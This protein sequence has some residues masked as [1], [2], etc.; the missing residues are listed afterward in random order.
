MSKQITRRVFL[1][2]GATGSLGAALALG[3]SG[4]GGGDSDRVDCGGPDSLS[5][6]ELSMRESLHYVD[7]SSAPATTCEEC[8]YFTA[9]EPG[10]ACGE[11]ELLGGQVSSDGHCDSW[12]QIS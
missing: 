2:Q 10:S 5:R 3:L 11:C 1:R 8:A 6:S 4:C 7:V 12:S 9:D